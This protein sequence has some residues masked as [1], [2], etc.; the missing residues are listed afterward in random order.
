MITPILCDPPVVAFSQRRI[1][2]MSQGDVT[3]Q[4]DSHQEGMY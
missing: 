4:E 2:N 1:L 3:R